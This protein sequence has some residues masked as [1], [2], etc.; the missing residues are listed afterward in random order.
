MEISFVV[1]NW[2]SLMLQGLISIAFGI[3][4]IAWPTA[5]VKAL[6][7]VFGVFTLAIGIV[8]TFVTVW[9]AAHSEHWETPLAMAAIGLAVGIICLARPGVTA[10]TVL[11]LI[12]IYLLASGAIQMAIAGKLPKEIKYRWLL[13]VQGIAAIVVGIL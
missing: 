9:H 6:I 8:W 13:A 11:Y 5:T 12:V 10:V 1:K 2:G 3:I 4:L 7:Y